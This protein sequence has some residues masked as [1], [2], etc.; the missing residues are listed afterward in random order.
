MYGGGMLAKQDADKRREEML[1]GNTEVKMPEE[2]K[3]QETSAVRP[4]C[5][6]LLAKFLT[7]CFVFCAV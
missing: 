4:H 1:M 6:Y 7:L 3:T 5:H 2:A